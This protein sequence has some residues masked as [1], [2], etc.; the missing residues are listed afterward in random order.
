MESGR[1]VEIKNEDVSSRSWVVLFT[2]VFGTAVLNFSSLIFASRPTEIMEQFNMTQMQLTAVS[3]A[4]QLPGALLSIVIGKLM[5]KRGVRLIP[6][7]MLAIAA[8]CMIW[9]VFAT[10]YA[11]LFIITILAGTFFLPVTIIAPKLIGQWFLPHQLGTA[12]GIFGASAGVGTTLAFALGNIFPSTTSAFVV[13]AIGYVI[14][15]FLWILFAKEN[16]SDVPPVEEDKLQN[17]PKGSVSQVVKS[18]NMW[19]VMITGG[20]AVGAALL[21][22]TYLVNAFIGKGLEVSAASGIAT[23][24]N[25]CL[26][27]GGVLSG[28][29]VSK[30][31]RYNLPYIIICVCGAVL[32]YIAY[33]IP[34][35]SLTYVLVAVGAVVVSGSIGVNM[36]RIPLIPMTGDF[37]YESVGVAGG[38][39]NTAVGICAFVIPTLVANFVGDNYTGIFTV[40]LVLLVICAV[41]GGILLPELGEKGK[42]AKKMKAVRN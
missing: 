6:S 8:L 17:I 14:M 15:L 1:V 32:Y 26:V 24:L 34:I 7:I 23:L 35:S 16:I 22:N 39:N 29:V 36:T 9:R 42:I 41:V 30:F 19:F 38:M 13:I 25:V 20:L 33:M 5:D 37:G 2:L 12:M 31:G 4:S 11:E 10:S 27:I 40:F 21:L 3:T 18:K 28:V